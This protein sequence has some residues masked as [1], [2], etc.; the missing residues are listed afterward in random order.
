MSQIP[1]FAHNPSRA[2]PSLAGP[3]QHSLVS[4]AR[5]MSVPD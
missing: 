2:V 3:V 1:A 4:E 5:S